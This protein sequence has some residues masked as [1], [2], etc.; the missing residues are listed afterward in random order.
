MRAATVAAPPSR[1]A[2]LTLIG[3]AVVFLG[4]L[5]PWFELAPIAEASKLL[6][7][8]MPPGL[9]QQLQGIGASLPQFPSGPIVRI[10]GPKV[11]D[12]LGWIVLVT[13]LAA[14][15]LPHF[16]QAVHRGTLNT[17]RLVALGVSSGIM[18]YLAAESPRYVAIG[19]VITV[20]GLFLEWMGLLRDE[21]VRIPAAMPVGT[22]IPSR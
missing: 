17:M 16:A 21:A 5:F 1:G 18:I 8:A 14:A 22:E 11:A 7:S 3:A 2:K 9:E 13:A 19:L 10:S 4:F 12:G 20:A 15:L 6:S